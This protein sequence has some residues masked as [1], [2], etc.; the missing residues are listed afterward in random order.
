MRRRRG[1][2]KTESV[3]ICLWLNTWNRF[4]YVKPSITRYCG[5]VWAV[6][7]VIKDVQQSKDKRTYSD[8]GDGALMYFEV[9]EFL[10]NTFFPLLSYNRS[11]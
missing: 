7:L 10:H 11:E 2:W 3:G 1:V 9:I 8:P 6:V 4:Y 5:H